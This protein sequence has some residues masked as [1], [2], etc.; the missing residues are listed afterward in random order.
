MLGSTRSVPRISVILPACN[1]AR[2]IAR[3]I[4]AICRQQSTQEY[5]LIVFDDA[6]CDGTAAVAARAAAENKSKVIIVSNPTRK[7]AN[8][9]RNLGVRVSSGEYLLF[10]D[11]DDV[12]AE[13]WVE[14]L[15]LGLTVAD[16]TGGYLEEELLN[17][18]E[19]VR[20]R[21]PASPRDHFD[22]PLNGLP[23]P[24]FSNAACRRFCWEQIGGAN[25][26]Y[27]RNTDTEFFWRAQLAGYTLIY[28]P[29]AVVH[30]R[31]RIGVKA[32][33][34]Q[35]FMTARSVCRLYY[36]FRN[37]MQLAPS[38]TDL[39]KR[40]CQW[41]WGRL[42]RAQG[43]RHREL[44]ARRLGSLAGYALGLL[45][46]RKFGEPPPIYRQECALTRTPM[47]KMA[48]DAA[49][50]DVP[51]RAVIVIEGCN[52][53]GKSTVAALLTTVL[54]ATHVKELDPPLFMVHIL[55]Q[56][57]F[58]LVEF[59]RLIHVLLLSIFRRRIVMERS[60]LSPAM[61]EAASNSE[62]RG[63]LRRR[64]ATAI[65][66]FVVAVSRRWTVII[67]GPRDFRDVERRHADRDPQFKDGLLERIHVQYGRIAQEK[68]IV[69]LT[70]R[71]SDTG[72]DVCEAV[73]SVIRR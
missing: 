6:S 25:P 13:G 14:A 47:P 50:R 48:T 23:R 9:A 31:H 59:F 42:W 34:S 39:L 46:C 1:A 29:D 44:S 63:P 3:Q 36:D 54:A 8:E 19:G 16:L 67:L 2:T 5:E 22:R 60:L 33:A 41:V 57:A 69:N 18:G 64:A 62:K 10:C 11:A 38:P 4:E 37:Q 55:G 28:S 71:G 27:L 65:L 49:G 66:R 40:E 12:V 73:L 32:N 72:Q 24:P 68:W 45:A 53:V 30:Y 35:A 61:F 58:Y 43:C 20:A 26:S 52:G 56:N 21:S 17:G 15:Y 7:G 70:L 51:G